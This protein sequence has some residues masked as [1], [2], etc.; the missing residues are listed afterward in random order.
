MQQCVNAILWPQTW[1]LTTASGP[2]V[3]KIPPCCVYT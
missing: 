3:V 2:T 1:I